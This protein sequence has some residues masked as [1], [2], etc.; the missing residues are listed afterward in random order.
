[1]LA[2]CLEQQDTGGLTGRSLDR[3]GGPSLGA[4]QVTSIS[5]LMQLFASPSGQHGFF[6]CLLC[7]GSVVQIAQNM[8]S[9]S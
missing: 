4:K 9:S 3:R 1:M 5:A 2:V 7:P 6:V 8:A